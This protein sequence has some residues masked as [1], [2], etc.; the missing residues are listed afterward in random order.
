MPSLTDMRAESMKDIIPPQIPQ[1]TTYEAPFQQIPTSPS[2]SP[3]SIASQGEFILNQ[4]VNYMKNSVR[5]YVS[6]F[7]IC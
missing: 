3:E 6:D 1:N 4:I 2:L 7:H 5:V